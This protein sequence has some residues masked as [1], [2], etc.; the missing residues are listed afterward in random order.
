MTLTETNIEQIMK[1]ILCLDSGGTLW[2]EFQFF[3]CSTKNSFSLTLAETTREEKLE[4]LIYSPLFEENNDN[5]RFV[6]F[7]LM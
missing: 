5:L 6:R 4:L 7:H 2:G 1:Q 3:F